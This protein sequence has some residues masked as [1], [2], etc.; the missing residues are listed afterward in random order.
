M[1]THE[2]F[3][4]ADRFRDADLERGVLAALA[5]DRDLY[6]RHAERLARGVF[7]AEGRTWALLIAAAEKGEDAGAV[8]PGGW[9][10]T[11]RLP[12]DV[13]RLVE[14]RGRRRLARTEEW[15]A[16][17]L[18][19][20]EARADEIAAELEEK[21]SLVQQAAQDSGESETFVAA[22]LLVDVVADAAWRM[23]RRRATGKEVMGLKS[24]IEEVDDLVG[25]YEE[26][27]YLLA[28]GPSVGKT[29]FGWQ[30]A[31][32]IAA[33]GTPAV[34]VSFENSA[35]NLVKKA[36]C[37]RSG[38]DSKRVK[39]GLL[40][41]EE[42]KRFDLAAAELKPAIERVRIVEGSSSLTVAQV[43]AKVRQAMR[44][45]GTDTCFVV[46][47]Y[48]QLWAKASVEFRDLPTVRERVEVLAAKIREGLSR[49]LKIPVLAICSLNRAAG[50]YDGEG[51]RSPGLTALK[52]TGDLEYTADVVIMLTRNKVRERE[53]TDLGE[54]SRAVN[55][56][57]EKSRD[58]ELGVVDL[59]F[60][61]AHA[62]FGGESDRGEG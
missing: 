5:G 36:V 42:K 19:D 21:S 3:S 14:L 57:V 8:V 52:E 17:A 46:L 1:T 7:V 54:K 11:A 12:E 10:R 9:S 43:R 40:T 38:V 25:G 61:A 33:A 16:D 26:G 60:D 2:T 4:L 39:R 20:D 24:G 15:L 29:T 28:A 55:L 56:W 48:L 32:A 22:D 35:Q 23:E 44:E 30:Q 37:A 31:V 50:G 34:H 62:R 6:E 13:E 49:R 27:M 45:S 58:D 59:V 53:S 18:A 41:N 47:D 51:D